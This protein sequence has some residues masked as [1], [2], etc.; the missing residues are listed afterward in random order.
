VRGRIEI[1]FGYEDDGQAETFEREVVRLV[2]DATV[3][4]VSQ[5]ITERKLTP[6][7]MSSARRRDLLMAGAA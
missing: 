4:N 5:I 6:Q 1:E 2:S 3:V 7:D